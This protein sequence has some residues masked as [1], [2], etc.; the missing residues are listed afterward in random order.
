MGRGRKRTLPRRGGLGLV[1]LALFAFGLI[2]GGVG[3]AQ[4]ERPNL[5][6][7]FRVSDEASVKDAAFH[8]M[9]VGAAALVVG[10]IIGVVGIA[11][12]RRRLRIADT[13]D[14]PKLSPVLVT[15]I[16]LARNVSL[17]PQPRGAPEDVAP[18]AMRVWDRRLAVDLQQQRLMMEAIGAESRI[19]AELYVLSLR[20]L[21]QVVKAAQAATRSI[22]IAEALTKFARVAGD[23][24]S[25]L[26]EIDE[27]GSTR[28]ETGT[29]GVRFPTSGTEID[30]GSFS[31]QAERMTAAADLLANTTVGALSNVR[32]RTEA[33]KPSKR[34]AA[35]T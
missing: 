29:I 14:D 7:H 21:V 27:S 3:L 25:F 9:A 17:E 19:D 22:V 4:Y 30:L 33:K 11:A 32:S 20:N 16:D 12:S 28:K 5:G 31:I 18:L 2:Q 24:D 1:G 13:N 15:K 34:A 26:S 23:A 8:D 10:A 35:R 6:T